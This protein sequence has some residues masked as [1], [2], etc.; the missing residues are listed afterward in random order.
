M[1]ITPFHRP[2]TPFGAHTDVRSFTSSYL[3][4]LTFSPGDARSIRQLGEARGQQE[5]FSR[6]RPE[7]LEDLRTVAAIESSE[8]S[9]RLEGIEAPKQRIEALVLEG[10]NPRGRSEQEIAGYR[11]ALDLIHQSAKEMRFTPNVV[12]QLHKMLFG[13][14]PQQGGD[15]KMTNN[16]IVERSPDGAVHRV[17]FTPVEAVATPGAMD[18][19]TRDYRSAVEAGQ[20]DPLVLIPLAILDFLCIHPFTDGNGRV[21]RLLT[22][23]LLYHFDYRVGRYISLERI[24][25]ESSASYYETLEVSSQGW[26]EGEHDS[27]PW[28]RY[29]WGALL[30]AYGEFQERVGTITTGKGSKTEQVRTAVGRMI[31]PFAISELQK[32]TPGVS[33]EMV[34]HVLRQM[35]DEGILASEGTGRGARWRKVEDR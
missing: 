5:L 14:L 24:F 34:R 29:F 10:T 31:K 30:K 35:R 2:F 9:N 4:Y 25:E 18:E 27:L 3:G 21:A 22:L 17:R 1:P 6:Q 12:R 19:L 33:K 15:W 23:M 7:V 8:S 26:H 32:L 16:E 13:Y 20:H 28:V 11:D